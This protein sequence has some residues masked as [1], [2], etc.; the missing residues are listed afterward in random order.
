MTEKPPG[1][2]DPPDGDKPPPRVPDEVQG[3]QQLDV[4]ALTLLLEQLK[5]VI[6]ELVKPDLEKVQ[7]EADV[8][9]RREERE[10]IRWRAASWDARVFGG[11]PLLAAFGVAL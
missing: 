2:G 10:Q 9:E 4:A 7:R 3:P 11:L 1:G 6:A 8:T 5:G